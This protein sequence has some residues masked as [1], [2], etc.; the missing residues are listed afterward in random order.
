MNSLSTTVS[1]LPPSLSTASLS[2]GSS[3]S[4]STSFT[5]SHA[6]PTAPLTDNEDDDNNVQSLL[7]SADP[8]RQNQA[9]RTNQIYSNASLEENL[10]LF[11]YFIIY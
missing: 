7:L 1:F 9:Q 10:L 2:N 8:S 3:S 11:H 4:Y 5:S 6:L